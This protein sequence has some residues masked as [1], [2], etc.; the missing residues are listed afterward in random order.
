MSVKFVE[1]NADDEQ[2]STTA[3]V[4]L[5]KVRK[6]DSR[7]IMSVERWPNKSKSTTCIW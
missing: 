4:K 5:R 7:S 1:S 6:L 2:R 3:A